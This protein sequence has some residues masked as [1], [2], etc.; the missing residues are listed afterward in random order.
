MPSTNN[1]TSSAAGGLGDLDDVWRRHHENIDEKFRQSGK[2]QEIVER[3]RQ[4]LNEST[5]AD[6]VQEK[7]E[8]FVK[9]KGWKGAELTEAQM[10]TACE[11]LRNELRRSIPADVKQEAMMQITD[12]V[13]QEMKELKREFR[14]RE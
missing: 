1:G 11:A 9:S 6:D 2:R 5:W 14:R 10:Q 4:Q 3:T 12:F 7:F 8:K 13:D